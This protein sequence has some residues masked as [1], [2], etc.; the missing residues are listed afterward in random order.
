VE[1]T[2]KA[3]KTAWYRLW[4]APSD[5]D[6]DTDDWFPYM[7]QST[8]FR[9]LLFVDFVVLLFAFAVVCLFHVQDSPVIERALGVLETV[10]VA[11]F[12]L[13]VVQKMIEYSRGGRRYGKQEGEDHE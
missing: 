2:V 13:N 4:G 8:K 6:P 9:Q 3:L 1:Q 12:G 11:Y 10:T 5:V 7:L